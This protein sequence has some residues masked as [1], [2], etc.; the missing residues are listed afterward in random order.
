MT[1]A[2]FKLVVPDPKDT[3]PDRVYLDY[4][5]LREAPFAITPDPGFLFSSNC[6]QQV[7]NKIIYAI[8]GRMGFILLTGEV[9]TGKTTLCRTLLDRL[10]DQAET[11]YIINPSVSGQ[12]LLASIL[13]DLGAS[14]EPHATKKELI[15]RLNQRLLYNCTDRPFVVI[16]DDAQTMTPETLE[17]LRLLSNLET[18]KRKLIQVVLSGQPELLEMLADDRLRQLRQRIAVNCRLE[19]LSVQETGAYISRRLFVAGNKGQVFFSP[20][21][22]RR[23]HKT[24]GGIPRQINKIC[25]YALTAGYVNDSPAIEPAHVNGALAELDDLVFC[26]PQSGGHTLRYGFSAAMVVVLIAAALFIHRP[27]SFPLEASIHQHPVG[28]ENDVKTNPDPIGGPVAIRPVALPETGVAPLP[29]ST[30]AQMN[31][32]RV[33]ETAVPDSVN[34]AAMAEIAQQQPDRTPRAAAPYALQ[35]GSFR[36]V[37]EAKRS[38]ARYQKKGIPAHWQ[39]VGKNRWYRIV[40]G[41][42]ED[43]DQATLY[44]RTHG[45]NAAIIIDAPLTVKVLPRRPDV[46]DA[47]IRRFLS[48][49]GYDSLMEMGPAGDNEIYTGLFL[50]IEDAT[51]TAERINNSGRLLAQVVSR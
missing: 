35:L 48:K 23:I 6:H 2:M 13:G 37:E 1:E 7:I 36:S 11:V 27:G 30:A 14:P 40:S 32:E 15:D 34:M 5:Q 38:V 8:D 47:D 43:I 3:T 25:D 51:I 19:P 50:S 49:I 17:D 29:P 9:G 33:T 45:L 4:Y 28:I 18:D 44:Q 41:K 31:A 20:A 10:G 24:A 12:E 21:A 39:M 46:S 16:I 42:F 22:T 26:G